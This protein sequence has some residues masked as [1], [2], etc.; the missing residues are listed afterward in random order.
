MLLLLKLGTKRYI[1]IVSRLT[2]GG[3][4][5]NEIEEN[6]MHTIFS[7][8]IRL[9]F[10]RSHSYLEK[11]GIYPGQAPL[12]FTLKKKDGQSQKELSKKLSVT[13]ATI[14]VMVQ[15]MEKNGYVRRENDE[16]DKRIS[17]IFINEK[18]IEICDELYKIHKE[19]EVECMINFKEEDKILLN[20]L[21]KQVRDNLI[22][23]CDKNNIPYYC[24]GD[25]KDH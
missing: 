22:K 11:I 5:L 21:L 10:I 18:G 13:P 24:C 23:A 20:N 7:Q 12:L 8:V 14:T 2:K 17:R 19:I 3:L 16:K 25:K 6:S 15:R 4:Q 1:I 9:H